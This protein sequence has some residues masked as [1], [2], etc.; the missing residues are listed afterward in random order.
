MPTSITFS[1][2]TETGIVYHDSPGEFYTFPLIK[3]YPELLSVGERVI[4]YTGKRNF[5]GYLGL[6][7]FGAA[8]VAYVREVSELSTSGQKQMVAFLK[9]SVFFPKPVPSK[10]DGVYI[11]DKANSHKR[12]PYYF[13]P[14]VRPLTEQEFTRILRLSELDEDLIKAL[15]S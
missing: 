9:D 1:G 12:P 7:Y 11:E 2:S 6:H 5:P 8:R 4:F 13:Q 15:S 14:G 10:I 3:N